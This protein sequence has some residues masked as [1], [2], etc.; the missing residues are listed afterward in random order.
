MSFV[1]TKSYGVVSDEISINFS[2]A[3]KSFERSSAER[4]VHPSLIKGIRSTSFIWKV[5]SMCLEFVLPMS[6]EFFVTYGLEWF[7]FVYHRFKSARS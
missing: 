7:I 6:I 3:L 2:L 1:C 5:L 4:S